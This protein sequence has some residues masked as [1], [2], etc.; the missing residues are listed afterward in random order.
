MEYIVV[1]RCSDVR[2]EGQAFHQ[3][4]VAA[5]ARVILYFLEQLGVGVF[6][7]DAKENLMTMR[8]V[9]KKGKMTDNLAVNTIFV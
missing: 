2:F 1:Y 5:F 7:A 8:V 6:M 9:D 4:N 3:R